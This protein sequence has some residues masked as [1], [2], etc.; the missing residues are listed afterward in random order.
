VTSSP[1]WIEE[2]IAQLIIDVQSA[3]FPQTIA[4]LVYGSYLETEGLNYRDIDLLV[5]IPGNGPIL[6]RYITVNELS[7]DIAGIPEG[8]ISKLPALSMRMQMPVGLFGFAK[9]LIVHGSLPNLEEIRLTSLTAIEALN[10]KLALKTAHLID[11]A[12]TMIASLRNEVGPEHVAI[13][14]AAVS[15]L[16]T[17]ELRIRTNNH[18][19][20]RSA[21]R[22]AAQ[23]Y[24]DVVAEY[25]AI[26]TAVVAHDLS[27]LLAK[28]QAISKSHN[29]SQP[30]NFEIDPA[31]FGL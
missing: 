17:A 31:K 15:R 12:M 1:A 30:R 8:Q 13:G 16:M 11:E 20:S 29:P 6:K 23:Q 9:G 24:P 25:A 10:R 27:P 28:S 26:A 7:F 19:V 14:L 21:V 4:T 5:V 18:I 22:R 3:V 2:K